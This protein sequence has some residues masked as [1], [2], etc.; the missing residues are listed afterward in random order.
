MTTHRRVDFFRNSDD[1]EAVVLAGLGFSTALIVK[2]TGLTP[3]Q[4]S[5]RLGK[6]RVK[7]SDYRNGG[8]QVAKVVIANTA[9]LAE[10]SIMARIKKELKQ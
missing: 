10:A 5:Y 3:C 8:S 4:V 6:A 1:L 9:D 7:R 2:K